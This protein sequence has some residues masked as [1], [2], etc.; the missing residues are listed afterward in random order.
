MSCPRWSW[1][2]FL[3]PLV[4]SGCQGVLTEN[5]GPVVRVG[6]KS[7]TE[8]VILGDLVQLLAS[9][10]GAD[11]EH[12]ARLGD[13][14]K[15]WNGLLVGDLDAY[16]EYTGTLMQDILGKERLRTEAEVRQALEARGLR[17]S[18]SLGFSNNYALGMKE[19]R[20]QA[21]DIKSISDL[22]DHPELRLGL[23]HAFIKRSDGWDGLKRRYRLPFSTPEGLEHTLAYKGLDN[24]TLDVID[25]YTTDAEI[26]R[27]GLRV[28][29]DD[30]GYFPSYEAVILYRADL[31]DRARP[32]VRAMLRLEGAIDAATMRRMNARVNVDRVPEAV[33]AGDFLASKLGV[34]VEVHSETLAQRLRRA[35]AQHLRLV[36]VSLLAAILTAVPLGIIAARK[37]ILGQAI[38]ALVGMVQTFPALALLSVLIVVLGR[39]GARPAIVAL[40]VYSLL[41]IVRNTFT[42]LHDIP[43]QVRESAE[44]LGLSSWARLRL[45]EL[46]MASRS[47]LAGVKTAAVINVGFATLGGLIGA[48]GYG[49]A[50]ISG[51]DKNDYTLMLEGAIPAVVMAVAVQGLFELAERFLVPRG[52]RLKP[53]E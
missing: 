9:S 14:S 19:E 40:Y 13:T 46:P 38:L 2:I 23:S 29:V 44:A 36:S 53:A 41:P 18:R 52:L 30:R 28:L 48:G 32:A 21:L 49:Q 39:I 50:I 43:L 10:A 31:E 47:I 33:V 51:L 1:L 37:P 42:G 5:D 22:R 35:T 3:T 8:S 26:Q 25:L 34:H 15:T 27:Y 6:S 17:M 45:I 7:F 4:I 16:V 20:A 24:G 11:V 12:H